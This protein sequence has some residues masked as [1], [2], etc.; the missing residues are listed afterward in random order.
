[1]SIIDPQ[2]TVYNGSS[3]EWFPAEVLSVDF[4]GKNKEKLYTITCR[5]HG[6]FGSQ[7]AYDVLHARAL[8]ANIKN[9]PIQGEIVLVT[10][11]PTAYA[12]AAG[13]SQE[14][15]YTNPVSI[16]SS[17]HHN[18]LPG[19]SY[20]LEDTSPRSPRSR[21]SS[22]DGITNQVKDRLDVDKTID[23]AYPERFDV[24]PI[25]PYSGDI[26]FEGRWG[27]SIRFGSTVDERRLYPQVPTWKKGLGETGN[28]ILIISNG[29]NPT[30]KPFNEFILENPD[31][32]DSTI[33]M[34]SGQYLKFKPASTYTPSIKSKK[35][36]L[37]LKN[38]FGGNQVFIASDRIVF[39][40]RKQEIIGY[41]KEGIG[42]SSEKGISLDG[43]QVVEIESEK[44]SLGIN[45]I[46]PILL[47]D[48]TLQWLNDLCQVLKSMTNSIMAQTHP[49]G[50][51]PSGVPINVGDFAQVGADLSKLIGNLKKLPSKLAF[52]NENPG[53][54]SQADVENAK[55]RPDDNY[56]QTPGEFGR[57]GDSA[58]TL[59]R[60]R[61]T[62]T[63]DMS[64]V[65]TLTVA[66]KDLEEERIE[67]LKEFESP[68]RYV[69]KP[70][71]FQEG[72]DELDLTGGPI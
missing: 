70:Q 38:E 26:I 69:R 68:E 19:L 64:N 33:W 57:Q 50:T 54:P 65:L 20:M 58:R 46:S 13:T 67:I 32:D 2:K 16:Q 3:Y 28:P 11:G 42:F 61:E 9:I 1:M 43:R 23:A 56:V 8:D 7:T 14:Y 47:G 36:D 62:E 24:Y 18:G 53:G 72:A 21:E 63:E 51:G 10:K 60:G 44:I 30:A 55:Q 22:Q 17:V 45:A 59:T 71:V 37:H 29:T 66:I 4:A 40:A 35:I 41:S 48:R 31:E 39:N 27:H 15:Y 49:T 25:Q 6:A 12:S 52:V 34:T 5:M